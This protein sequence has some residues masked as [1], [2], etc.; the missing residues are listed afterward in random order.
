[1]RPRK[2]R[3]ILLSIFFGGLIGATLIA[4]A[5]IRS[6]HSYSDPT[7][8][9]KDWV[10][11]GGGYVVCSLF[12]DYGVTANTTVNVASALVKVI[13]VSLYEAAQ[14]INYSVFTYCPRHWSAL[15]AIG[16]QARRGST[17]I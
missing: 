17:V 7:P 13:H 2:V 12:D 3:Q 8:Y 14:I 1:M 5:I 16:E 4:I 15:V 6:P 11:S 9:S 10:D